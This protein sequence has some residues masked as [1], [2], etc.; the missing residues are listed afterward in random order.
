MKKVS[1]I[2]WGAVLITIGAIL[3]LNAFGI[4]DINIFFKGWWT[5]FIIVPG[6]ISL[7]TDRDKIG[8]LVCI[9][10]GVFL[11]LCCRDVLNFSMIWKLLIP[12]V[13][14]IIGA[15]MIFGNIFNKKETEVYKNIKMN[16]EMKSGTATFS[17]ANMNFDGQVFEGAELN[18]VFGGVKC[19]LR[20]AIIEKD[21]VINATAVFGGITVL[22][23]ENLNVKINSASVFGGASDDKKAQ[24]GEAIHTLY[25]NST[26]VFGGFEVK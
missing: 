17:A 26:C 20:G 8:S 5:L 7:V 3:A 9:G 22:V 16:C 14:I 18:A 13:I 2:L 24:G 6:A 10:I 19:D 15:K 1:N 21:C 11:L 23:P 4:T 25:V 12:A